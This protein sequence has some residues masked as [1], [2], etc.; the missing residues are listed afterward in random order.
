MKSFTFEGIV[1]KRQNFGEADRLVTLFSPEIGKFVLKA[2]GIRKITSRRAGSLELFNQVKGHA[3]AGRGQIDVLTEVSVINSF[4]S[5]K[6]YLGRVNIAYQL[7]EVVDKLLP[8]NQPHPRIYFLL[9]HS[10]SHINQLKSDWQDELNTWL[11]EILVELGYWPENKK[12]SGDINKF[13]ESLI[14]RPLNSPLILKKL[15]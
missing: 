7:C 1:I 10:L 11:I 5:W 3:V 12:F 4:S 14:L 13:I 8:E 2:K 15:S 6:Q 9:L